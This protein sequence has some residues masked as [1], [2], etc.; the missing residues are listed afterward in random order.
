MYSERLD[1]EQICYRSKGQI[2]QAKWA[3]YT[4]VD[5]GKRVSSVLAVAKKNHLDMMK[6]I[7]LLANKL[8]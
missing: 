4:Y 2:N 6:T 8:R 7:K 3:K 5:D 1:N